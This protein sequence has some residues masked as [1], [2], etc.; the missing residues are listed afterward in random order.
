MRIALPPPDRTVVIEDVSWEEFE[1]IL[2]ELEEFPGR[3]VAYDGGRLEIVSPSPIHES[4]TE[5]IGMLVRILTDEYGL[6]IFSTG[7]W[8]LKRA[9]LK[10]AVEG[11]NSFYITNEERVRSAGRVDLDRDPPPDLVIE[12]DV[13]RKSLDRFPIYAGIISVD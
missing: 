10:R 8:T 1:T 3:R 5:L 11:D 12:V 4:I 6:E 13:T 2:Q 7:S 9:D